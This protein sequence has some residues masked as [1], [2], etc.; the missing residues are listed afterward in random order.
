MSDLFVFSCTMCVQNPIYGDELSLGRG[1]AVGLGKISL[2]SD[3]VH[4]SLFTCRR[5]SLKI[6]FIS[7]SLAS[8]PL[9]TLV[10]NPAKRANAGIGELCPFVGFHDLAVQC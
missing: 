8:P 9:A 5:S 7:S 2:R 4:I 10:I 1:E 6:C 3:T